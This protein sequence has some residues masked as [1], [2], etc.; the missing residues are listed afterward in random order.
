MCVCARIHIT[1]IIHITYLL[2]TL[3]TSRAISFSHQ[4]SIIAG[5]SQQGP[6]S[7]NVWPLVCISPFRAALSHHIWIL[8]EKSQSWLFKSMKS[9]VWA[10]GIS[11]C[12]EFLNDYHQ[13][14]P[15]VLE[16]NIFLPSKYTLTCW[17]PSAL[18]YQC[19]D[20]SMARV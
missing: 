17:F 19:W 8:F 11:G 18:K 14:I 6:Q 5:F 7:G 15:I 3:A 9:M 10:L 2:F 13:E 12:Y 4:T 20:H 16:D 1:Y